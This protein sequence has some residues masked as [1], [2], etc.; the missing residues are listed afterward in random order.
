MQKPDVRVGPLDDLAIQLE[1]E[2]QHAVRR[3]ML[4]PK[5]HRVIADLACRAIR[6]GNGEIHRCEFR[7]RLT[8]ASKLRP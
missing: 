8:C 5:I 6:L 7:R 1:H 4:R 2:P 3:W